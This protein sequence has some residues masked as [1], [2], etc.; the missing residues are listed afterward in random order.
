MLTKDLNEKRRKKTLIFKHRDGNCFFFHDWNE[1][2]SNTTTQNKIRKKKSTFKLW[3]VMRYQQLNSEQI[4]IS[5]LVTNFFNSI[6][7]NLNFYLNIACEYVE[8][9]MIDKTIFSLR[10]SIT[11]MHHSSTIKKK[12]HLSSNLD[13]RNFR[14]WHQGKNLFTTKSTV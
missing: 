9:S 14:R 11:R 5:Y 8:N 13:Y 1:N 6:I 7:K 2:D 3:L 10:M 4:F 12:C